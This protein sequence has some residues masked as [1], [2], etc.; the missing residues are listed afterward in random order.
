MFETLRNYKPGVHLEFYHDTWMN[1][2][3]RKTFSVKVPHD[4]RI[5]A[6]CDPAIVEHVLI[7]KG[8]AFYEKGPQWRTAF[9]DLLGGGIFNA[10]GD[11]WKLQ[12]KLAAHE[13][14]V[15][16]LRDFMTTTFR[17]HVGKLCEIVDAHAG[18]PFD[19][20]Q[21][22]ARY[23]LDSIGQ[24]GFGVEI[25]CLD[26]KEGQDEERKAFAAAFD[27]S[28]NLIGNRFVDPLWKIK[29]LLARTPL[30]SP[31][32]SARFARRSS[33]SRSGARR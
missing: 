16:S 21:L 26:D 13:F 15:R 28:T 11:H 29:R 18:A 24:I 2:S 3:F 17:A 31:R 23:T 8:P 1:R 14:S 30:A 10:D 9:H 20:Q 7:T 25:G 6:T 27:T 33:S 32:N 19:V 12:R 5:F 22:F 4:P